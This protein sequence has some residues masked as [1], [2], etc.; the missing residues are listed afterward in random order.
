MLSLA[1]V[2][3][4]ALPELPG[5]LW[6]AD[7]RGTGAPCGAS[8]LDVTPISGGAALFPSWLEHWVAHHVDPATG[9]DEQEDTGDGGGGDDD[10]GGSDKG[11][12]SQERVVVPFNALVEQREPDSM[13]FKLRVPLAHLPRSVPG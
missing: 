12:E 9:S 2:L 5:S 1:Q 13:G 6:F 8:D 7:P 11:G 10:G 4:L 3:W